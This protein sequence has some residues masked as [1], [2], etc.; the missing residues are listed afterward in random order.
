MNY[1]GRATNVKLEENLN[2]THSLTFQIP[3]GYFDSATGEFIHNEFVDNLYSEQ[4]VK[5]K[6]D[7]KWY[8]F[9]VKQVTD[10]KQ[11]N[12]YM[13]NYNCTDVYIEE[14]SRNGYGIIFD[15]ELYNNVEEIGTFTTEI[16][17]GSL[18]TYT[19]EHNWGDF[20]E[21][22]EEKLFKVPVSLFDKISGYKLTYDLNNRDLT[23]KNI[24]TDEE[25]SA[26][27]GD[28]L[29]A[30]EGYFWD[31][32]DVNKS[33]DLL[34][35]KIES[36]ENDGYIY[37]PYSE[38][39]F[40]YRSISE[41]GL[42][43]TEEPCYYTKYD[44]SKS[45]A[46]AP[47]STNPKEL[48]Q[49]IAFPKNAEV[50][51]DE[52]GLIVNKNYSYV[53]TIEDWNKNLRSKYF[54]SFLPSLNG[55][56]KTFVEI[57]ESLTADQLAI[58]NKVAY[59]DGYLDMIGD[60]EVLK[61]KKISI[62]DRTEPNV[63]EEIDQYTTVYKNASS[64][65][66][67]EFTLPVDWEGGV[68]GYRVCS[69]TETRQIVPQLAR[70]LIQ[71][72]THLKSTTGWAVQATIGEIGQEDSKISL[73][74]EEES[75][76]ID[77]LTFKSVKNSA[78]HF[79]PP[80]LTDTSKYNEEKYRTV[81]N[82]GLVGQDYEISSDKIYCLGIKSNGL[83]RIGGDAKIIIG[84]G[85]VLSQG[86]YDISNPRFE[87]EINQFVEPSDQNEL[88][89]KYI[90]IKFRENVKVPYIG[91]YSKMAYDLFNFCFFEA[92]TKGKDQFKETAYELEDEES[93]TIDPV[94]R[95]SGRDL[96][97]S[98]LDKQIEEVAGYK[99]SKPMELKEIRS[100]IIFEDDVMPGDTYSYEHYYIQ[101]AQ[102]KADNTKKSNVVDSF[103]A[104][105]IVDED[106]V[107]Q[108]DK[109]TSLPFSAQE[110]TE[111]DV[112]FRTAY[113][114]LGDCPSYKKD[115]KADT[116]DCK[117]GSSK[118]DKICLYQKYGYCPY[119]FESEKHCRKIRTLK[120]EKSNRFNL[121]QE[122]SKVF[123]VY[124]IYYT[125]H[126]DFGRLIYEDGKPQKKLFY[127]TEKGM[128]NK[129]GFRYEK[130]LQT[131][132]RTIKSDQIVTKLYVQ[133]V[134]SEISKT[135]MCSIKTAE[136]NP[137]KDSFIIDFSYYMTKGILNKEKTEADLYGI[138][139]NDMGYLKQLGYLNGEYD[140]LSNKI[141]TLSNKSF[142]ELEAN[143]EVNI[144][145][146]Q[147]AQS[148]LNKYKKDIDKFRSQF[149]PQETLKPE[150]KE[151]S[152]AEE[153]L[154]QNETYKSYVLKYNEQLSIYT[155]LI[156][157]TFCDPVDGSHYNIDDIDNPTVQ[158]DNFALFFDKTSLT[159]FKDSDIYKLHQYPYGMLGQYNREYQQIQE[160][161]KEQAKYLR[162]INL[163]SDKFQKKYEAYLKEGTWS[164]SNYISDNAYYFGA[165]EVAAEGAI[166]KVE[167]NISVVDIYAIPGY[168]DYKFSMADTTYVE[169][170]GMFGINQ[171]TGLPNRLK[172]LVSGI[173]YDLDVP[174]NNQIKVQ[175]F[176]TQF[177]DLFQQV[178]A[179]V[180]SLQFNENIYKRA[181]N[182]T[183]NRSVSQSSLQGALDENKVRLLGTSE[184]NIVLD[185]TGQS[186][187]DMNNHASKY[188]FTGQGM[189]FSQDGGQTWDQGVGPTGIN[190]DYIK[191]GSLDAGKISIVDSDYL[192]FLWNKQ[193]LTAFKTPQN[194]NEGNMN[195]NDFVRFNRQGLSIVEN[196]KIRLRTGYA[197]NSTDSKAKGDFNKESDVASG[198]IGFYLYDDKGNP[199]FSTEDA[200][201][202]NKEMSARLS[203]AGEIYT[204]SALVVEVAQTWTYDGGK[205]YQKAIF[206]QITQD[207]NN[208]ITYVE[209]DDTS[210]TPTPKTGGIT[211]QNFLVNGNVG[212][213]KT[214]VGNEKFFTV[215]IN[216]R[217]DESPVYYQ[218]NYLYVPSVEWKYA[219]TQTRVEEE[220]L[221]EFKNSVIYGTQIFLS[222]SQTS[223]FVENG[224]VP[225]TVLTTKLKSSI[226]SGLYRK[227]GTICKLVTPTSPSYYDESVAN[228]INVYTSEV[229]SDNPPTQSGQVS[230]LINN[231]AVGG[232]D[233]KSS[234]GVNYYRRLW[235]ACKQ[236]PSGVD[237]IMTVLSNGQIIKGG[238]II[239]SD[240]KPAR[241][242]ENLDSFIIINNGS[243][244]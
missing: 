192:Y 129:L 131:I 119:R 78:L 48:I 23:I 70:N 162:Q 5:L 144:E 205:S 160:W 58:G 53:M 26:E 156:K 168:E 238:T 82:F 85:N 127:I 154:E 231:T 163:I 11:H 207:V 240:G 233:Y 68:D 118:Y 80:T 198:K 239:Q 183:A 86:E 97:L 244:L 73:Y 25:R 35:N 178:T 199:I 60:V 37:I 77:G 94:F 66:V 27:M 100:L 13:K 76:D 225:Q 177:E 41:Q 20:T 84:S 30:R 134:D 202:D 4:K 227:E 102:A 186:G 135:G 89:E 81:I 167:Y 29:A 185:K 83:N 139:D 149:K 213:I 12:Y 115:A 152:S 142:T 184:N 128:E 182:F 9:Y 111:D 224:T 64:N 24:Y 221:T 141:I 211:L 242:I 112:Q 103:A 228:I 173:S 56:A 65:Y 181:S 106:V 6:F 237:N 99:L 223:I 104:R 95:Y 98:Y 236:T 136:D 193:G 146:I 17:D 147:A 179:S 126:D 172:V 191:I 91:I 72:S 96:F 210:P 16:L 40:C 107:P 10:T 101:Q 151:E 206:M 3:D 165:K 203:L 121:T 194:T 200:T 108:G 157:E 49:F 51:I 215:K 145:G 32:Y 217:N 57:S 195:F 164:D 33:I 189:I 15:E 125:E 87:I 90:L 18:W 235:C 232:D 180:Q 8:E 1:L 113:I 71:N 132:G 175:N 204:K 79:A 52:S 93:I 75:K 190:A 140:S 45:Y 36:I 47:H 116:C 69:K 22:S 123:E 214:F 38:L 138:D 114:N 174:S 209:A 155:Q 201:S 171:K 229:Y 220:Q 234:N 137:S 226:S 67:D 54:Y 44:G 133:D 110:F 19:P 88:F 188:R 212:E 124:P 50:E 117:Y 216:K 28:D 31:G 170:L 197:F 219:D 222:T 122:L 176:T 161:K 7:D 55:K 74:E 169:D 159:K 43:A 61:G 196:G 218:G 241:S 42:E 46:I 34:K 243:I 62:S 143:L 105:K 187:S 230:V 2:G 158:Q 130:N 153:K 166:P 21:Y 63:S 92:Y 14:L 39:D 208:Y 120:G 59:Y 148:L 150:E 109:Y